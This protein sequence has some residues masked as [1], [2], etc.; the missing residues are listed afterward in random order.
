MDDR[1]VYVV[2]A[3]I[4]ALAGAVAALAVAV[5][6]L[7]I[8]AEGLLT[9]MAFSL[10]TMALFLAVAGSLNMNGQWSWRFLIFA[11]V[12][13]A[14]VPAAGYAFGAIDL[15]FSAVIVI[16]AIFVILI[17]TAPGVKRWVDADRA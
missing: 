13:C 9:K 1:P 10:L 11:E 7:D 15:I 5:N 17:T 8:E 12:L 6:G 3:S 14:A 4:L 2:I 16:I